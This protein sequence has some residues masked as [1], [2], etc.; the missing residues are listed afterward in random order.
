MVRRAK[1]RSDACAKKNTCWSIYN[2]YNVEYVMFYFQI[3]YFQYYMRSF[4][5]SFIFFLKF[6][7]NAYYYK[8]ITK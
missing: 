8:F 4:I 5:I 6:I 7:E 3:L 2:I 1:E